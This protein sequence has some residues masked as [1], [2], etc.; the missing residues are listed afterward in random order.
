MI[1]DETHLIRYSTAHHT[2]NLADLL[3]WLLYQNLLGAA[4]R[5]PPHTGIRVSEAK[6]HFFKRETIGSDGFARR[7]L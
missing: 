1:I 4:D 3:R 2:A 5:F 7:T 6:Q